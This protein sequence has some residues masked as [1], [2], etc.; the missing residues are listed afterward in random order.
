VTD[1]PPVRVRQEIA[2]V[3]GWSAAALRDL[4][5]AGVVQVVEQRIADGVRV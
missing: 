3:I 1:A 4:E 2:D 5:A